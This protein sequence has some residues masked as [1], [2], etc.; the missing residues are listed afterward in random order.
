LSAV[1]GSFV[2]LIHT[3]I[4]TITITFN[5]EIIS[6]KSTSGGAKRVYLIGVYSEP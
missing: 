1:G 6:F 3:L 4:S 5:G 2:P